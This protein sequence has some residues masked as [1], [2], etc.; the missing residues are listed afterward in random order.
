MVNHQVLEAT[1]Q[2]DI[3]DSKLKEAMVEIRKYRSMKYTDPKV[4]VMLR[5]KLDN[6]IQKNASAADTIKQ[7][8]DINSNK[9]DAEMAKLFDWKDEKSNLRDKINELENL[10]AAFKY[11]AEINNKRKEVNPTPPVHHVD[12]R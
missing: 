11:D 12:N 1:K 4:V 5:K 10:V 9:L 6:E 7:I 8:I 3:L 2:I